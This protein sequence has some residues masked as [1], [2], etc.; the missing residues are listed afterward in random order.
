MKITVLAGGVGGAKL[1]DGLAR[2]VNPMDL[3]VIVNTG[4]DFIHL[5]LQICPD[6]DTVCYTLAGIANPDTGWGRKDESWAVISE[7]ERLG[8]PTWFRL[9]DQ[10]LATHLERTRR[11]HTGQSL[12]EVTRSFCEAWGVSVRVLPM[13]DRAVSTWVETDELGWLPFQEYFVKQRCAPRVKGFNFRNAS[14]AEPAPDVLSALCEAD[15]IVI[16]PSNPWVSIAPI[17]SI[18]GILNELRRR[19]DCIAVSP[20]IGG[21]AIKGPAAKMYTEMGLEPNNLTVAQH[22]QTFVKALIVDEEDRKETGSIEIT[23]VIPFV[24]NTYMKN[25]VDRELLAQEVLRIWSSLGGQITL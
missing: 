25:I 24:T 10:D 18:P 11:L 3:T 19:K 14:Q 16:A 15:L 13:S 12:S 5:G 1:V 8:G 20:L 23:G 7:I 21:K 4:D 17:L 6:L 9:G 22:Y 2:I